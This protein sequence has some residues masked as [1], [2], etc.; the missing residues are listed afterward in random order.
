MGGAIFGGGGHY[1]K[2]L[3]PMG[4]IKIPNTDFG[5][6]V[7]F[8][9]HDALPESPFSRR[10]PSLF[11]G[12][13]R[14]SCVGARSAARIVSI[15]CEPLASKTRKPAPSLV[16]VAKSL[17]GGHFRGGTIFLKVW[18]KSSGKPCATR[19]SELAENLRKVQGGPFSGVG[20]IIGSQG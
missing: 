17:G 20:A 11:Y 2:S 4:E 18:L 3:G 6:A 5:N 13:G 16:L 19:T 8:V 14:N 9:V 15:D 7:R 1:L 10:T 12:R